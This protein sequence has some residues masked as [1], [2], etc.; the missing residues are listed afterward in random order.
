LQL[1]EIQD[2][3]NEEQFK[4]YD[5]WVENKVV[6]NQYFDFETFLSAIDLVV[7]MVKHDHIKSNFDKIS[8]KTIFDTCNICDLKGTYK[9]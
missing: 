6:Q 5:P 4:V 1:L 7:I 8:S 3:K 9:L 2:Q